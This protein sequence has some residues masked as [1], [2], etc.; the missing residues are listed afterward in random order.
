M[1]NYIDLC[2]SESQTLDISRN[3]TVAV[4]SDDFKDESEL[5]ANDFLIRGIIGNDHVT[6]M[7]N[8]K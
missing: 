3:L 8:H 2:C 4:A 1:L 7:T 5:D 6:A